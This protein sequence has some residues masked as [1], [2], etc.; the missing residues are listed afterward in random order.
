MIYVDHLNKTQRIETRIYKPFLGILVFAR[1]HGTV[2]KL[3]SIGEFRLAEVVIVERQM[4][5]AISF[6]AIH[7]DVGLDN[8]IVRVDDLDLLALT[9]DD[10]VND[11]V[12]C[13]CL[14]SCG[15]FVS[16]PRIGHFRLRRCD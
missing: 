13:S 3:L 2:A 7:L 15:D 16:R 10:T 12:R 1:K 14:A 11:I 9:C 5:I 6:L 4:P 8:R